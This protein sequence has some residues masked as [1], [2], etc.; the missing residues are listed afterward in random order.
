M[1]SLILN[2]WAYKWL[3]WKKTIC[4]LI[5]QY[6]FMFPHNNLA[7]KVFHLLNPQLI[8]FATIEKMFLKFI[9]KEQSIIFLFVS[10]LYSNLG[11]IHNNIQ[12][13]FMLPL[14]YEYENE[15][16]IASWTD[17]AGA[18]QET[19]HK[20]NKALSEQHYPPGREIRCM[21]ILGSS[22]PG[23]N[24]CHLADKIFRCIFVNGK[25]VF[26]L[27]YHWSLLPS[28][29]LTISPHWFRWWLGTE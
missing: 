19:D 23:Q 22:P 15:Y 2:M 10:T 20:Q 28:V 6:I 18:K 16:F 21:V 26:W 7:C 14:G 9:T 11:C 8:C 17:M 5:A 27:K 3:P 12:H 25:F 13:F 24:G 1:F 4:K 29:Q